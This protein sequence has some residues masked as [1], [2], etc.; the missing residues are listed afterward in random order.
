LK[1]LYSGLFEE[2]LRGDQPVELKV[3][4]PELKLIQEFIEVDRPLKRSIHP[5]RG[6]SMV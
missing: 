2:E 5:L 1:E 3:F 4:H 6:W